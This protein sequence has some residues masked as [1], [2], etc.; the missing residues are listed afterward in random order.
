[1][2]LL[3]SLLRILFGVLVGI[4]IFVGIGFLGKY[5]PRATAFVFLAAFGVL[6]TWKIGYSL[7]TETMAVHAGTRSAVYRR[8]SFGFWFY[9]LFFGFLGFLSFSAAVYC[10]FHRL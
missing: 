7:R 2:R 9:I 5:F 6:M 8:D 3:M 10:L 1:M 4:G